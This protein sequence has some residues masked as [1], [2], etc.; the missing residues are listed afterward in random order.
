M[1]TVDFKVRID[2]GAVRNSAIRAAGPIVRRELERTGEEMV[3]DANRSME[4]RFDLN[5]PYERRRHPGS[6]RAKDALDFEITGGGERFVLGFRVLGGDD[7]F[8]RILWLNFG[9]SPHE[10]RPSG[11]WQLRGA[12][13]AVRGNPTRRQA[14]A[15]GGSGG[16]LYFPVPEGGPYKRATRV[17]HPGQRGTGFL[18]EARDRAAR[19]LGGRKIA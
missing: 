13:L 12:R 5:R 8:S 2:A 17:Q 1:P 18:E 3:K 14:A 7:V 6:R 19:R 16:W 15:G 10:I 4:T 11:R 9:T